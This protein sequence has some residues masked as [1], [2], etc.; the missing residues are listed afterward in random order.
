MS[1]ENKYR[2]GNEMLVRLIQVGGQKLAPQLHPP[3]DPPE[4]RSS[5]TFALLLARNNQ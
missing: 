5:I 3:A 1:E 4:G 2:V